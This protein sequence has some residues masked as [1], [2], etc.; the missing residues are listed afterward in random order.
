[1][2]FRC[3]TVSNMAKIIYEYKSSQELPVTG[4]WFSRLKR[5]KGGRAIAKDVGP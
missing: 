5:I 3:E 1:M 2:T 4:L